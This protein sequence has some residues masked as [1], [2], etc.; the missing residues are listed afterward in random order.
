MGGRAAKIEKGNIMKHIFL[1]LKI[2]LS[3]WLIYWVVGVLRKFILQL[4]SDYYGW[5]FG[6]LGL[7]LVLLQGIAPALI[8][9]FVLKWF[10]KKAIKR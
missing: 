1:V 3:I 6:I 5:F 2:L 8:I 10:I 4:P 9:Y 7:L